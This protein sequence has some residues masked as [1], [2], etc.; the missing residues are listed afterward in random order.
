MTNALTLAALRK[1]AT[2]KSALSAEMYSTG[3]ATIGAGRLATVLVAYGVRQRGI[4]GESADASLTRLAADT[5][6]T[7]RS[8]AAWRSTLSKYASAYGSIVAAGLDSVADADLTDLTVRAIDS[9]A[10]GRKYLANAVKRAASEADRDK[11]LAL[12]REAAAKAVQ[13]KADARKAREAGNGTADAGKAGKAGKSKP[14]PV[15]VVLTWSQRVAVLA[16]EAPKALAGLDADSVKAVRA[17]ALSIVESV[18]DAAANL[19]AT[20]SKARGK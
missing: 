4:A 18:D 16:A 11:A 17:Y 10:D 14:E 7:G 2:G 12:Y 5:V 15:T 8:E 13:S 3:V 6:P 20:A 9:T 19:A 1:F